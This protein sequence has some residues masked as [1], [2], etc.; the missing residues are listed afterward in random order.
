LVNDKDVRL[1]ASLVRTSRALEILTVVL[2]LLVSPL[3]FV[4]SLPFGI[5]PMTWLSLWLQYVF[6]FAVLAILI[7]VIGFAAAS[8]Y[9][10]RARAIRRSIQKH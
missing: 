9:R 3:S 4:V 5:A 8:S 7:A 1:A 2:V 6:I 10:V